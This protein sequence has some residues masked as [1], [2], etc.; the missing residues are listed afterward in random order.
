M[1]ISTTML[2]FLF[3]FKQI[4]LQFDDG[5][6]QTVHFNIMELLSYV[7]VNGT[8]TWIETLK[9]TLAVHHL[10]SCPCSTD[11]KYWY[12]HHSWQPH[13]CSG[14][15]RDSAPSQWWWHE[16]TGYDQ[17]SVPWWLY[18]QQVTSPQWQWW[19]TIY[20]TL[21]DNKC[22]RFSLATPAKKKKN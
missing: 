17:L 6:V 15:W 19:V 2:F 16:E 9:M 1:K 4:D 12:Q 3:F 20:G 11:C 18:Q 21:M 8:Y 10:L 5:I 13:H 7:H 14:A 22:Q